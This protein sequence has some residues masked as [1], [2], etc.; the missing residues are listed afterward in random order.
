MNLVKYI[1]AAKRVESWKG[2]G[3]SVPVLAVVV[4]IEI[5]ITSII[6]R[7]ITTSQNHDCFC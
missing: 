4:F 7:T 6:L 1:R 5:T 2:F 3:R